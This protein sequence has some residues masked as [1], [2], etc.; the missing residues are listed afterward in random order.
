M[1][2]GLAKKALARGHE[3]GQKA[4][5]S[6]SSLSSTIPRRAPLALLRRRSTPTVAA[7]AAARPREAPLPASRRSIAALSSSAA[8]NS[9]AAPAVAVDHVE[10][11]LADLED[12]SLVVFAATAPAVRVAIG[13]A[14]A[15]AAGN[16]VSPA[17]S[18]IKPGQL[19]SALRLLGFD[20]VFDVATGADLTIMEEGYEL[21]ARL[22]ERAEAAAAAGV[23]EEEEE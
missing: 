11:A 4:R 9:A 15:Q 16:P 19:V 10:A 17:P 22:A 1:A 12:D 20:R 3:E 21:L 2:Q 7:S 23:E 13:E 5:T 18:T 6:S 8:A 14:L